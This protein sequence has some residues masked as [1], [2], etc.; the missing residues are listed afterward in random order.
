MQPVL[1]SDKSCTITSIGIGDLKIAY[2]YI[3]L[4]LSPVTLQ[5]LL[6]ET[7]LYQN[8]RKMVINNCQTVGNLCW[9]YQT[10]YELV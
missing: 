6:V 3:M 4:S 5:E 10:L 7:T 2:H 8:Y 9:G 1:Y